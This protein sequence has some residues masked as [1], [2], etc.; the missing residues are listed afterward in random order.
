[1]GLK[2]GSNEKELFQAHLHWSNY[3]VVGAW[4]GMGVLALLGTLLAPEIQG[5]DKMGTVP[6]TAFIFFTPFLVKWLKNKCKKYAV[7]DKRLYIEEG[8]LAKNKLDIPFH[9]ANDIQLKQGFIQRLFGSGNI[10]VFT[11]NS[12]PVIIKDIDNPEDF[13]SHLF[14]ITQQ[15]HNHQKVA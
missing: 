12:V 6:L 11:G 7:T 1:M 5:S 2:L 13:K 15:Q 14:D 8:I 9:K 10:V 4:F 3:I